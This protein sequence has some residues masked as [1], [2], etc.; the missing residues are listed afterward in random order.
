LHGGRAGDGD[1]VVELY[2][3]FPKL[4]GA[5]IRA[6]RGF[7]RVH[8]AAGKAAHVRLSL[9][10]RDLSYVNE[11]GDRLIAPGSYTLS[12]GGGQPG[13][14]AP[15]SETAFTISGQTKLPE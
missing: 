12:I 14:S 13:T 11:T 6:L 3:T 9:S 8:V 10:P 7:S 4:P 1:E 2:V 5:P 15:V